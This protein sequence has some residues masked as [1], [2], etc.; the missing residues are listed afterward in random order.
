MIL[1][2]FQDMY[3]GLFKKKKIKCDNKNMPSNFI[4]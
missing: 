2:C 1:K 4:S 3:V